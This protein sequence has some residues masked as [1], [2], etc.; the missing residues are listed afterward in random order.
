MG[1]APALRLI[2]VRD[3]LNEVF[4]EN[5]VI[6]LQHNVEWPPCSPDLTPCDFF[7]WGYLKNKV[8]TTPSENIDDLRQRIIEEFSAYAAA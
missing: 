3:R 8:F 5:R 2:E 7:L 4:G 6:A 1:N